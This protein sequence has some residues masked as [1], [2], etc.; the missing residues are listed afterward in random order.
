MPAEGWVL[1][2]DIRA[3]PRDGLHGSGDA[4]GRDRRRGRPALR[5]RGCGRYRSGHCGLDRGYRGVPAEAYASGVG[6]ALSAG[7][8]RAV[9]AAATPRSRALLGAAAVALGAVVIP[10]VFRL[11]LEGDVVVADR[12]DLGAA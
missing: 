8:P 1:A 7:K 3:T 4:R 10:R 2:T 12:A 11:S 5:C 6:R 9:L